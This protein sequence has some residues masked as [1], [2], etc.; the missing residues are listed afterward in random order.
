MKAFLLALL[1]ALTGC[2]MDIHQS[3]QLI[4]KCVLVRAYDI[5]GWVV[6]FDRF[7]GFKVAYK[8]DSGFAH[9]NDVSGNLLQLEECVK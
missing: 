6:G 4:G 5:H 7:K 9:I 2:G 3:R 1:I 8:T